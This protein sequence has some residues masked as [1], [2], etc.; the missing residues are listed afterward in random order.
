[1]SEYGGKRLK[2]AY[3]C[4]CVCVGV[5]LCVIIDRALIACPISFNPLFTASMRTCHNTVICM[6]RGIIATRRRN[7]SDIF[8]VLCGLFLV[9]VNLSYKL[10]QSYR[11]PIIGPPPQLS[12]KMKNIPTGI[13]TSLPALPVIICL[14]C[15]KGSP[16][17]RPC[18]WVCGCIVL[19]V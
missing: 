9:T 4:V 1:M 15:G 8:L 10:F 5:C 13:I 12:S 18:V 6:I 17:G 7:G 2:W 11:A 19:Q 14:P 16:Q 3:V